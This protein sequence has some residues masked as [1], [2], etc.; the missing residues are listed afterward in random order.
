[1]I[2]QALA[3]HYDRLVAQEER[4]HGSDTAPRI[5]RY[6]YSQ[7][8]VSFAVVL[9]P[10][11]S[12]VQIESRMQ[13]SGGKGKPRP[14]ERIVPG[15]AKPSGSGLNPCFLW[16]NPAYLLGLP[17]DPEDEKKVARAAESFAALR[18]RHLALE[19]AIDDAGY[20]AVCRF[21]E[22]WD[23]ARLPD[24]PGRENLDGPGFGVFRLSG[25]RQDVHE[26]PAVD[27]FWRATL[28]A[29]ADAAAGD[30]AAPAGMCLVTG[31][32]GPLARLHEPKIKGV[33]GGQS[34]GGLIV[35]FN[36]SAYLSQ[37]HT[38]GR[39][40]PTSEAA[41]FAYCT[42][43]N[44]L[45]GDERSRIRLGDTTCVLW[46]ERAS[47]PIAPLATGLVN[48]FLY[49]AN[50]SGFI[51]DS[52]TAHETRTAVS[53]F[54]HRLRQGLP[55][56]QSAE[57]EE[58]GHRF[59]LLGLAPNAARISIRF[60]LRSTTGAFAEHLAAHVRGLEIVGRRDDDRPL[61]VQAMLRETVRDAKDV[62]PRL[63][64]DL[65]RAVLTGVPYPQNLAAGVLRRMRADPVVNANRA[66]ILRAW[67]NRL[68]PH[69]PE[70]PVALDPD[71][72][73]P[74]YVLGRLF[75]LYERAQQEAQGKGLNRT[76]RDSFF[77]T[78]S[79][80]P[81]AVFPRLSR[82]NGNHAGKLR[83]ES[84]GRAVWL[85][86]QIGEVF[87]RLDGF[88]RHLAMEDQ[89]LFAIGYHHQT[90]DFFRKRVPG[91]LDTEAGDRDA[92]GTETT[93]APSGAATYA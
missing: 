67:L 74:P 14:A 56:A 19:E 2:L 73:D 46:S 60:F 15:Q 31:R 78:A 38:D 51:D 32:T 68:F 77:A 90:Q 29:P 88:P 13:E 53:G 43:L 85:E 11:G 50:K 20:A 39:N 34:S 80:T 23:P 22:A 91:G 75:A 57:L 92:A 76:I 45:L 62:P 16:D 40:A 27:A 21:L 93:T 66:A 47:N 82:L 87:D 69:K 54:L 41:A 10:D 81:A 1:M 61:S 71:R 35:S 49:A 7:Q 83:R 17:A 36:D 9:E 84:P 70:I 18:E 52:P 25:E 28:E 37:G 64:G 12:L 24:T 79:S 72:S 33:L 63:E 86:K 8:K 89:G 65:L 48:D 58:P 4:A 55:A 30:D 59:F 44:H 5:A 42:A 26:R 3:E 6:G